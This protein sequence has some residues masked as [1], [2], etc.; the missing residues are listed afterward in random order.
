MQ[1]LLIPTKIIKSTRK[2]ISLAIENNGDFI[3]RAPLL[4]DE[5]AIYKFINQKSEWIIKKRTEQIANKPKVFNAMDGETISMLD[6]EY[7]IK[8]CNIAR[9]KVADNVI[10]L[11]NNKPKEKLILFL[12]RLAKK[13]ITKEIE[14]VCNR[15]NFNYKSI[16]IN[17]AKT[18]WGSCSGGNKLHFSYKLMLCPREV[19][20]YIII[21]ELCHTRIMNHSRKYWNLVQTYFKNYKDCEKWLK[22]NRAVV[23]II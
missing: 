16:S 20:S 12:K 9:V 4:V 7:Y 1:D 15:F 13:V 6:T 14:E 3:V 19:V 17:S 22:Q 5:K 10:Y 2:S 8:L 23:E 21:H 11:P 18:R